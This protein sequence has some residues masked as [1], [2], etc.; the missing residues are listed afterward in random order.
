MTNKEFVEKLVNIADNYKTL[1]VMG[2]FGAPMTAPNKKRYIAAWEY[3]R[4]SERQNMINNASANTFG[5]DCVNLIKAVLWGWN[6][7][8]KATYGGAK[9]ASNDVPDIS[10]NQMIT[11]CVD[12]R[13][14]D[15]G[16]IQVGEIVWMQGHVGVYVG[17]GLVVECSPRW[18][19]SVQ[20]TALL[21]IGPVVGY[22]GRAWT[23]HGKL[24][25]LQY[26]KEDTGEITV[27]DTVQF[28]GGLHYSTATADKG[29]AVEA[30]RARVTIIRK[31]KKHPYHVVRTPDSTSKVYGWVDAD[32]IRKVEL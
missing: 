5:F 15:W 20:K 17:G 24:P 10:A 19:N 3:N 6:G 13:S 11:K 1:Y 30:G 9:Y 31:D 8:A 22:N 12:V 26:I 27:G 21:N 28:S 4:Q 2:C 14:N 16:D 23:R 18:K 25:W 29:Y 7:N 32:T